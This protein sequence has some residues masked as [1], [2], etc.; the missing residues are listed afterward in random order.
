MRTTMFS[1]TSYTYNGSII[2]SDRRSSLIRVPTEVGMK[3]AY[4]IV[5]FSLQCNRFLF[6]WGFLSKLIGSRIQT[7]FPDGRPVLLLHV[8]SSILVAEESHITYSRTN[9][10]NEKLKWM[11]QSI[12]AYPGMFVLFPTFKL[13]PLT[14]KGV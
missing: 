14:P 7:R 10:K 8:S 11:Q 6:W 9:I 12:C 5:N 3:F 2:L 13:W 1:N 4:I